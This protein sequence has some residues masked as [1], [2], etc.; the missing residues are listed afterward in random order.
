MQR[1][2]AMAD[3]SPPVAP[4][5][6][7]RPRKAALAAWI[8]SALEYY[9]FFIY[10]TSAALVFGKVFFPSASP[11]AGTLLS[12]ATFGVGYAAR[13]VGAFFLGH[14]GDRL[15]RKR[16]LF[17][18]LVLMGLSTF[19]VGCL[20]TFKQIGTAAPALLVALRLLQGLSAAGE[21]SSAGSLSLEHAPENRRAYYS[22]FTLNGT[23]AGQILATLAF[24][25]I[26][27]LP[28]A[29][30]YTWGWRIPFLASAI[31]AVAGYIIRR[32][33]EET[34]VFLRAVAEGTLAKVP[35]AELF[36]YHWADV[37]RVVGSALFAS[38]STVAGV[39]A[40][41]FAVGPEK[42][43]KPAMLW[44]GVFANVVAL[45]A[46]P[47]WARLADRV[48]RKPIF[49][50]GNVG[51]AIGMFGYLWAIASHSLVLV[52]VVGILFMGVV[53]SMA[54]G[55]QPAFYGEMFPARVRLSGIAV[56][57]Q[58]GYA[59]AGFA[60]TFAASIAGPHG[61]GWHGVAVLGVILC[62]IP[63]ITA[64]TARET[65]RVPTD[66]LGNPSTAGARAADVP[67]TTGS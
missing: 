16:I 10:G 19:L 40:L 36:R 28:D 33:M 46:I 35:L 50:L 31:I 1:S 44:L 30:L 20:P 59:I 8:G 61:D 4:A 54:N 15:G 53:S 27:A 39:W 63:A 11:A 56:G 58:I 2:I 37:L 5:P 64:L 52:F 43:S 9:D 6:P 60:A 7:G 13:P 42:L 57:T 21:Q 65:F 47:L 17:V 67:V 38:V 26:S 45:M 51:C 32:R 12:L 66:Q 41:S 62:A 14:F 49:V 24:L 25:P 29:Q 23:Q 55:L 48:G 18:T 22:S 3:L 34:P